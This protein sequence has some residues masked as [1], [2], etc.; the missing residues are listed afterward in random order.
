LDDA[1]RELELTVEKRVQENLAIVR[2]HARR[3]AEES[4][5]LKIMEK[6]QA[7]ASMMCKW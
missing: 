3:E 5:K 7:I 2:S 1:K 6:D 4:L